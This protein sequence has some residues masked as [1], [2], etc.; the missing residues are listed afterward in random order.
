MHGRRC[1]SAQQPPL[2]YILWSAASINTAVMQTL[3][4][5]TA[6]A[7]E[8]GLTVRISYATGYTHNLCL[9]PPQPPPAGNTLKHLLSELARRPADVFAEPSLQAAETL[10]QGIARRHGQWRAWTNETLYLQWLLR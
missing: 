7:L 10:L 2:V 1:P 4:T 8:A 5:A 6:A 9:E 3:D